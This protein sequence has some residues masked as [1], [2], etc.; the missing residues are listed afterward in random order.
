MLIYTYKVNNYV[1]KTSDSYKGRKRNI[2]EI[3]QIISDQIKK[4]Q[5]EYIAGQFNRTPKHYLRKIKDTNSIPIINKPLELKQQELDL[6]NYKYKSFKQFFIEMMTAAE[7]VGTSVN[8]IPQ[9]SSDFYATGDSRIV[10]PLGPIIRRNMG[11]PIKRKKKIYG[12][13][14]NR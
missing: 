1:Y 3:Q 4:K 9:F 5:G 10:K 7:V 13:R 8:P 2:E 6:N 11:K 12:K 14:N